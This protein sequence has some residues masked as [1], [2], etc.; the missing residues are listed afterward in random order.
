LLS[1]DEEPWLRSNQGSFRFW[2]RWLKAQWHS[3]WHWLKAIAI[4]LKRCER[5]FRID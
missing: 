1:I 4:E 5:F 3:L 2:V